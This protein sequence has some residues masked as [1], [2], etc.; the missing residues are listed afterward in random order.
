MLNYW[1]DLDLS[2]QH[3]PGLSKF[4]KWLKHTISDL[5]MGITRADYGGNATLS[6]Y[7]STF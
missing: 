2:L 6:Q 5:H 3:E 4:R 1:N 7:C